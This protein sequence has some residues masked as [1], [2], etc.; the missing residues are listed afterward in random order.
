VAATAA[1]PRELPEAVLVVDLVESTR[2]A[3]HYGD[4]LAMQARNALRDRVLALAGVVGSASRRA[5]AK[6]AS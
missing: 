6:A 3:T 2:L 1:R 4:G 5:P